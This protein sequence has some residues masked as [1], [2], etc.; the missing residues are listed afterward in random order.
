MRS[1]SKKHRKKKDGASTR[2]GRT[3]TRRSGGATS[4]NQPR[5]STRRQAAVVSPQPAPS[6]PRLTIPIYCGNNR[7]HPRANNLGTRW[8]CLKKGFGVGYYVLDVDNSFNQAFDPIDNIRIYCGDRRLTEQELR[9]NNYDRLGN[10]PDCFRK[11]V[12]AGRRKKARDAN[13]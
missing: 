13:A 7:L 12:G 9:D 8:S 11:G 2:S 6:R 10:L 4:S 3:T 1:R 5:P